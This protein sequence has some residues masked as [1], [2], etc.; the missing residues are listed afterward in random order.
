MGGSQHCRSLSVSF[1]LSSLSLPFSLLT[2]LTLRMISDPQ[3]MAKQPYNFIH[4]PALEY[5]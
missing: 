2:T 1:A 4:V 5:K 3:E